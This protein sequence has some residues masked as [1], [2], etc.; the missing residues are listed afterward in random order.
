MN[1]LRYQNGSLDA[2]DAAI[3]KALAGNARIATAELA[4]LVASLAT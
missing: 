3:L 1:R 4:R 2:I